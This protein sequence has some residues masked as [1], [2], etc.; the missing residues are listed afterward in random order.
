MYLTKIEKEWIELIIQERLCRMDKNIHD[1]E[2]I[3]D[4]VSAIK[5]T[6]LERETLSS[7]V[8]KL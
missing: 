3:E 7:I 6:N 4:K 2:D 5:R 8:D 1:I